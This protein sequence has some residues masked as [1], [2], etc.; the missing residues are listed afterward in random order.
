MSVREEESERKARDAS[1]RIDQ[2][3]ERGIKKQ[4]EFKY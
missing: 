1:T 3:M 2:Q 4:I